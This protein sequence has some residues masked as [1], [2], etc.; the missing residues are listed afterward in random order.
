MNKPRQKRWKPVRNY[1][2]SSIFCI[3]V[4]YIYAQ[5]SHDVNSAAM[6]WVFLFPLLGGCGFFALLAARMPGFSTWEYY[7]IFFNLHNS[8]IATLT[9]S[10]FLKG[11]LE[12]AGTDSRYVRMVVIIGW[13]ISLPR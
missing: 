3:A 4:N 13:T 10:A 2:A 7:R 1:A 12:I 5:F 8:G 9:A 6:T 11:I